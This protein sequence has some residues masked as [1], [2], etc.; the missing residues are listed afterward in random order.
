MHGVLLDPAPHDTSFFLAH[1][2]IPETGLVLLQEA[3]HAVMQLRHAGY[4]LLLSSTVLPFAIDDGALFFEV[5]VLFLTESLQLLNE[6]I[7]VVD[8][9]TPDD[10]F[11]EAPVA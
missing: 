5:L 1:R 11:L 6:V 7:V 2:F 8:V 10:F 4:Q 3:Q 9:G